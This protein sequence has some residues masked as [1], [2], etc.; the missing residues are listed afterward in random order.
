MAACSTRPVKFADL[1]SAI[2]AL[3]AGSLDAVVYDHP[4]LVHRIRQ[5]ESDLVVLPLRFGSE[6][7]AL[8][9]AE[10]SPRVEDVN[11]RLLAF[12]A[13]RDWTDIQRRFGLAAR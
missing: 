13:S 10:G 11:R 4:V 8:A 2:A 9:L 6:H 5:S 1:P 12:V 3:E 7:Y